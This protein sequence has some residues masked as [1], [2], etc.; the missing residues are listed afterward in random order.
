ME[1]RLGHSTTWDVVEAKPN[2]L[3]V[4]ANPSSSGFAWIVMV[5]LDEGNQASRVASNRIIRAG[6][7]LA[8]GPDKKF[9]HVGEGFSPASVYKLDIEQ[10]TA[11]IVLEDVHGSIVFGG[12]KHL[13]VSPD[14]S[15]LYLS[16]GQVLRTE[17]LTGAGFI[18]SGVSQFGVGCAGA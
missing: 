3:F 18:G 4:S 1:R 14:G 11:P 2:R 13:E 7:V 6:P 9:L 10:E 8:V 15:R 16:S 17:T 5:K 12:T